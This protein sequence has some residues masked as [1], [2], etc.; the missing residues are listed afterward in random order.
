M[1]NRRRS[2]H[3]YREDRPEGA[4]RSVRRARGILREDR[5]LLS[6]SG[7]PVLRLPENA[8]DQH[9]KS[10]TDGK[11]DRVFSERGVLEAWKR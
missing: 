9:G 11:S 5:K 7:Q 8:G 2:Y 1:Q 3:I 10:G 4:D 6:L